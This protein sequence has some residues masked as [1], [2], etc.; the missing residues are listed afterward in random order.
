MRKEFVP[1][2]ARVI[3]RKPWGKRKR[4]AL[5]SPGPSGSERVILRDPP[6][7][8]EPPRPAPH[9]REARSRENNSFTIASTNV[10]RAAAMPLKEMKPVRVEFINEEEIEKWNRRR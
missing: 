1:L 4:G 10:D 9:A 8:T 2:T 5:S 3:R 7:Q 6:S